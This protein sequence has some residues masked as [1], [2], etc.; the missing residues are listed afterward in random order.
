MKIKCGFV[1]LS[2][3][4]YSPGAFAAE[5]VASIG[6]YT[7]TKVTGSW[8][9]IAD[10]YHRETIIGYNAENDSYLI[11]SEFR[12]FSGRV[13]EI[14]DDT[15]PAVRVF[16]RKEGVEINL[17]MCE[18]RDGTLTTVK[19]GKRSYDACLF[20]S[21][22]GDKHWYGPFPVRGIARYVG[23]QGAGLS[24]LVDFGWGRKE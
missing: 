6:D 19:V 10:G 4:L 20:S 2:L 9:G 1:F 22:T 18:E 16:S 21:E 23:E 15:E 13:K 8:L 17:K 24:Q 11:K 5:D 12:S 14:R 7:V 3:C